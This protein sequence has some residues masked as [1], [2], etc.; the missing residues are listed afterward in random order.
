MSLCV[1]MAVRRAPSADHLPPGAP[2]G[3]RRL[4][5]LH[6][7]AAGALVLLLLL[8][9]GGT[10]GTRAIVG[11]QEERLLR[12]RAN[13][14]KLVFTSS[15]GTLP[16]TLTMLARV[17]RDGG[18]GL[19]TKEAAEQVAA[20]PQTL[21]IALLKHHLGNFVV[22]VAVGHGLRV[23]Q[24][25]T[26]PAA[27][28]LAAAL[29]HNQMVATPVI[30]SAADRRVGFALG[31]QDTPPG[32][33]VYRQSILGPVSPPRE[34]G[35]APFHELDVVLY[36]SPSP[37]PAQLLVSTT[38]VLPLPKPSRY[39][40]LAVG[41]SRWLFGV[42]AAQP[43]VGTV[44]SSAP[45]VALGVG[46]TGSLLVSL[47]LEQV[48]RRRDAAV[49]L[50][51]HEHRMAETFQRR[52]L[53]ELAGL[54]GLD[55]AA[56][57]VAA[58]DGQQVGGD[59]FDA[60]SL[61]NGEVAV[62]IGDVMGHDV[63]AAAAMAQVRAALRAYALH[64]ASPADVVGHLARLVDAFHI[65][66][67]VSVI[68]GVLSPPDQDGGR[69]FRWANAGH[70]PPLVR[71]ADG[72]VYELAGGT[73]RVIGA[74]GTDEPDEAAQL[75][76]PGTALVLY[77]DGLVEVPGVPLGDCIE[78]L[79]S[80]LEQLQGTPADAL[81]DAILQATSPEVVR[82]DIALVVVRLPGTAPPAPR[83]RTAIRAQGSSTGSPA[84]TTQ[85]QA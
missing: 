79:R 30:G 83:A 40:P 46:T 12:E 68:Y 34:A 61:A 16:T 38:K 42:S 73:C 5:R 1:P 14:V 65:T 54:P 67:L 85:P 9:A 37:D 52:L 25:V 26:G 70:L 22:T 15:L 55:V 72:R 39:L 19:F 60:F 77:T 23:G 11:N 10:L 20:S 17:A 66:A 71:S 7:L 36:A 21:T 53:P 81:C 44:A 13:E 32:T 3:S 84:P 56:R 29:R 58:A 45:W 18:T 69:W 63:S 28:A 80:S 4:A 64:M 48:V 74:P 27:T 47:V 31:G 75:L 82:D 57:Y 78:R 62:V 33:V 50:Y 24:D 2:K 51:R 76:E 41:A 43:L 35:T 8:T 59:W 49:A 6:P